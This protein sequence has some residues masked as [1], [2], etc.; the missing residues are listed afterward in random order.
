MQ[1]D[2]C[3][4]VTTCHNG[5]MAL[6][7]ELVEHF[8]EK[9]G[10]CHPEWFAIRAWLEDEVPAAKREVI[11]GRAVREWVDR[12]QRK[13][14]DGYEV[15]ES[16]NFILLTTGSARVR[17]HALSRYEEARQ[18]ILRE[19]P[20]MAQPPHPG[21]HVVILTPSDD[22]YYD[23]LS[24]FDERE[25]NPMSG[26]I[27]LSNEGY[28][29][30]VLKTEEDFSS[31]TSILVH[32]LTHGYLHKLALPV[33]MD[34]AQA[35]HMQRVIC[36]TEMLH[37]DRLEY[38]KHQEHWNAETIQQFWSG[39]SW[40]LANDGFRLGYSLTLV[41]WNKVVERLEATRE[42]QLEFLRQAN[43]EDAGEA[44]CQA[45]FDCSLG[46]LVEDFLGEGDWVPR[47]SRWTRA[48][49]VA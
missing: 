8:K 2:A 34:E 48:N 22:D 46:D 17:Q 13:F 41:L 35:M 40:N 47:P 28:V 24:D 23:Y 25:E 45:I 1:V 26:G 12:L 9:G 20:A 30:Y 21:P 7:G 49:P 4:G 18:Y 38:M 29:H 27:C 19:Y 10:Y 43:R 42:E 3:D 14:G 11:W 39:E 5:A 32:E 15:E 16:E 31:Y 44:A 6:P 33:W 37:L 36:S